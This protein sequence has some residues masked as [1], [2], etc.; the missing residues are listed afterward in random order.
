LLW[1][2]LFAVGFVLIPAVF[3]FSLRGSH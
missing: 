1:V 2:A 3:A